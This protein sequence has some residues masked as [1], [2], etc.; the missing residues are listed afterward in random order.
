MADY[1][2]NLSQIIKNDIENC[3]IIKF[4]SEENHSINLL[5]NLNAQLNGNLY[6]DLD[7][8]SNIDGTK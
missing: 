7:L 3:E 6:C 2:S 4:N 8:V 5:R 1:K